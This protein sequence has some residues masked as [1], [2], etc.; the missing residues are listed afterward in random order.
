MKI[1]DFGDAMVET[2]QMAPGT[3]TDSVYQF[4]LVYGSP[5]E[6]AEI[7]RMMLVRS[8]PEKA[9]SEVPVP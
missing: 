1:V 9:Q 7:A 4:G 2:K 5:K 8:A 3:R 6:S